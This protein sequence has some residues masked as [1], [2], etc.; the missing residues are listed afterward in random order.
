MRAG[1]ES[2]LGGPVVEHPRE[3]PAEFALVQDRGE[4]AVVEARFARIVDLGHQLGTRADK[5]LEALDEFGV[6]LQQSGLERRCR[7]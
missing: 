2:P 6:A 5:S 4:P 3:D 7:T 1:V